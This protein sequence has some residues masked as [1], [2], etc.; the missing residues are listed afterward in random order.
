MNP[1]YHRT[2]IM[3][4]FVSTFDS[5]FKTSNI[6]N[7]IY[8][9]KF[10]CVTFNKMIILISSVYLIQ[11]SHMNP[12]IMY[13]RTFIMFMFELILYY[14]FNISDTDNIIHFDKLMC[15]YDHN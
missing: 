4:M 9:D 3:F 11:I 5:K 7:I 12:P 6:D 1:L 14:E 2:F 8:F 10:T 15:V 13:H